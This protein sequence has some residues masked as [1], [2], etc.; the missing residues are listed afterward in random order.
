M[1]YAMPRY[2]AVIGHAAT[3]LIRRH[4]TR[5]AAVDAIRCCFAT[6]AATTLMSCRRATF[7]PI[8]LSPYAIICRAMLLILRVFA[9]DSYTP[10]LLLMATPDMISPLLYCCADAGAM[11]RRRAYAAITL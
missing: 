8:F 9:A 4:A 10:A 7:S 5:D 2:V 6:R 1:P 3:P 11:P